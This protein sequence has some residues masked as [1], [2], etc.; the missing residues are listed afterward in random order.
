MSSSTYPATLSWE[1][2]ALRLCYYSLLAVVHLTLGLLAGA[3]A[4]LVGACFVGPWVGAVAG[5]TVVLL[6]LRLIWMRLMRRRPRLSRSCVRLAESCEL[7][8]PTAAIRLGAD[9][10]YA[11]A[12]LD[13]EE[14]S[15]HHRDWANT[16]SPVRRTA[17]YRH[18]IA[19]T[20]LEFPARSSRPSDR[21]CMSKWLWGQMRAHG[22]RHT[23]ARACIPHIVAMA[24]VKAREEY[25]AEEMA[26]IAAVV[27]AGGEVPG[28][29]EQV[30]N[31]PPTG[32]GW[33]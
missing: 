2:R 31:P 5:P 29:M 20:R 21:A 17:F 23:H 13:G 15:T 6:Y 8:T 9:L 26:A 18:W 30:T 16:R 19:A 10:E 22:I 33:E 32:G 3:W 7:P 28:W 11:E 12:L 27:A 14:A 4:L 1:R 24:A 25:E